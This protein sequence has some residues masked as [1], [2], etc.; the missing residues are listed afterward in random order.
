MIADSHG[1]AL[2]LV[3]AIDALAGRNAEELIH[4]GDFFDSIYTRNISEV[5]SLLQENRIR[6]V[7]GNNDYQ[8]EKMLDSGALHHSE[9]PK[10][11]CLAFLKETP[12][13]YGCGNACFSHSMPFDTIRSFYEPI[14][15]GTTD[16]AAEVFKNTS[17]QILYCGHSHRPVFFRY[18]RGK[19]SREKVA[20]GE[21]IGIHP[22]ERFIFIVGSAENGEC[23][24]YNTVES[25]Y[26]RIVFK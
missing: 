5:L 2:S 23:G 16:R 24:L 22:R 8:V 3:K 10:D 7:K 18:S 14:D 21:R 17:C 13:L 1:S 26:E 20:A 4:L 15:I 6:T 11:S 25:F 19:V 9:N 12:L